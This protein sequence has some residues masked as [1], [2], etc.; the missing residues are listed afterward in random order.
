[1]HGV[2]AVQVS[3]CVKLDQNIQY[4]PIEDNPAHA[5]IVGAKPTRSVARKLAQKCQTLILPT[6]V[7]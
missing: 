1:M 3:L 6:W 4:D 5:N 7:D 2:V